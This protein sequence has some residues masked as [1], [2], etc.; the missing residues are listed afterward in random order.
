VTIFTVAPRGIGRVDYSGAIEVTTEPF[1]TSWQGVYSYSAQLP[2]LA[3]AS[4]ETFIRNIPQGLVVILYDFFLTIPSNRLI[5]LVVQLEDTLGNL[6]RVVDQSG[7]QTVATHIAKGC[8][9]VNQLHLT[10]Y[11]YAEVPEGWFIAGFNGIYTTLE[12][13]GVGQAVTPPL[14]PPGP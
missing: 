1:V 12:E 13:F 3:P 8:Y 9:F 4:H 14:A 7:Y 11:N 10:A 2:P 5:R 6:A